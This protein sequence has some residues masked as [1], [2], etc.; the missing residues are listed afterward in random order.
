M[1]HFGIGAAILGAAKIY[2]QS[3]RR[4]GRTISLVESVKDGDRICFANSEEADRVRRLC[5]DRGINVE[6]LVVDPERAE[7]IFKFGTP[8]GRTLLDHSWVELYY[9]AAIK[10]AQFE[11]DHLQRQASGWGE[12]HQETR[13]RA[14]EMAKW[15]I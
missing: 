4:T 9:L 6:C 5:L 13:R 3:A 12:P 1:D 14:E 10:R 8:Q 11:I 7:R 2:M 15:C